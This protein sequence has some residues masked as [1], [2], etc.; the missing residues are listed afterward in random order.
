MSDH[1]EGKPRR[2]R[3]RRRRGGSGRAGAPKGETQENRDQAP[4]REA[5]GRRDGSARRDQKRDARGRGE[6]GGRREGKGRGDG[7][8]RRGGANRP[9]AVLT[10]DFPRQAQSQRERR[11]E[12][13][14][15]PAPVLPTPVCPKCGEAIQ[16]VTSALTD[17]DS[18]TPI[19]FDCALKFLQGAENVGEKEK[20]VYIGQGRFAVMEFENPTDTKKFR[21]LRTIEWESRENRAEWRGEIAGQ[22]SQVR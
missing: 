21:I 14:P 17:R 7:G 9:D 18:G 16:D 22:Y 20:I 2:D 11:F 3:G 8:N 5:Q 12:P 19:H 6:S 4:K 15:I 1:T 10:K 13:E